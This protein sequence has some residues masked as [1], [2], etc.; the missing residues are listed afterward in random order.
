M[1]ELVNYSSRVQMVRDL[2]S[3]SKDQ[4]ATALPRH[5]TSDRMLRIVMTSVQRQPKLLECEPK[6]LIAAVIQCA[7]LGLEPDGVLG[8]AYLVPF[9]N[10]R[11]NVTEVQFIPGYKGLIDLARRSGLLS[12]IYARVVR[13]KDIF[14]FEFGLEDRLRHVPSALEDPGEMV[15]V[16]AVCKMRDGGVQFEVMR[17]WEIDRI[18]ARSKSSGDGPWVTDYEEMAKKTVLKRLCKMLPSSVERDQLHKAIGFDEL[19]EAGK[20]QMLAAEVGLA[21]PDRTES[22]L[23]RIAARIV[24]SHTDEIEVGSAPVLDEFGTFDLELACA[25]IEIA[26]DMESLQKIH[27]DL[28]SGFEIDGV[29]VDPELWGKFM[30]VWERRH[31]ALLQ[32]ERAKKVRQRPLP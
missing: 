1:G 19:H 31:A 18:R 7:Q 5:L 15:A 4:I 29:A 14:D 25:N 27:D 6:S 8:H 11:K 13:E 2:L 28:K 21:E 17:K 9:N 22:Q 24:D 3:R 23:A 32:N 12:T 30:L 16:Y 26:M 10:R 20:S